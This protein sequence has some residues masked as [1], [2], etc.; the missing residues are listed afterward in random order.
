MVGSLTHR[1][2]D[3]PGA[4]PQLDRSIHCDGVPIARAF[5]I[6][7]G[8]NHG[9]WKWAGRWSP[10]EYGIVESLDEALA[11]IKAA[12]TAEKLKALPPSR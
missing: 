7:G 9:R 11:A 4:D 10:A 5:Q 2:T 12:V 3:L 6:E 1:P 8:Q